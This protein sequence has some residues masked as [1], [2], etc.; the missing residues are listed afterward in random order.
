MLA[1]IIVRGFVQGVFYRLHARKKALSLGLEGSLKNLRDGSVEIF[2]QGNEKDVDALVEWCRRGPAAA[3]V[4]SV[5]VEL[6]K[7]VKDFSG[8]GFKINYEYFSF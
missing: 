1:R 3:K 2:A 8:K 7:G 5:E 4:D 6:V